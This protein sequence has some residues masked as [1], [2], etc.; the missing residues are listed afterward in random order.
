MFYYVY[1][2]LL[3]SSR[4]SA[5]YYNIHN[6]VNVKWYASSNMGEYYQVCTYAP[7]LCQFRLFSNDRSP[8]NLIKH[9]WNVSTCTHVWYLKVSI[10]LP[11]NYIHFPL[12]ICVCYSNLTTQLSYNSSKLLH[13]FFMIKSITLQWWMFVVEL[14]SILYACMRLWWISYAVHILLSLYA[15]RKVLNSSSHSIVNTECHGDPT[16]GH[17]CQRLVLLINYSQYMF[18]DILLY[19]CHANTH[20]TWLL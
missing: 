10:S 17:H 14:C 8:H 9:G 1:H 11:I 4:K 18:N 5:L 16:S 2:D 12:L 6:V 19:H 3:L 13:T 15:S 7:S 20:S